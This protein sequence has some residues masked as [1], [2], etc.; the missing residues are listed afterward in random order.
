MMFSAPCESLFSVFLCFSMKVPLK[1]NVNLF[2]VTFT[3]IFITA[4]Y[5]TKKKSELANQG[6]A[7]YTA[8]VLEKTL[9]TLRVSEYLILQ[10]QLLIKTNTNT[11]SQQ[12]FKNSFSIKHLVS[13]ILRPQLQRVEMWR[14]LAVL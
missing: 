12:L 8:Y 5:G 14:T 11:R 9:K 1:I 3:F 4:L 2:A 6:I 7:T 13:I 10:V